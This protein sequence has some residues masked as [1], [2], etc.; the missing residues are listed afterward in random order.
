[1]KD[2]VQAA[3][4][5]ISAE[6]LN[7]AAQNLRHYIK[8]QDEQI[9]MD[10]L[11]QDIRATLVTSRKP[12]NLSDMLALQAKILDAAFGY[13]MHEA[14]NAYCAD[15]KVIM[16]LKAQRQALSTINTLRALNKKNEKKRETN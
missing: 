9:T 7:L 2:I 15:S 10:K 16:A 11:V 8:I 13:Y 6:K 3:G 1:M 4:A 14:H 5:F 12:E